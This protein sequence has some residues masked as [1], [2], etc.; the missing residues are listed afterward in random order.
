[1]QMSSFVCY[2]AI[3]LDQ[4]VP[5]DSPLAPDN[6]TAKINE[7]TSEILGKYRITLEQEPNATRETVDEVNIIYLSL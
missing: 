4:D 2:H 6:I 1:M 5:L 7:E 3:C